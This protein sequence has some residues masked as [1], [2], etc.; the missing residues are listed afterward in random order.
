MAAFSAFNMRCRTCCG[1]FVSLPIPKR[2][3]CKHISDPSNFF[4]YCTICIQYT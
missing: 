4:E 3:F 2:N 1:V